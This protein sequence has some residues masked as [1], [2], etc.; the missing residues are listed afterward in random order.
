MK[1]NFFKGGS[2][3]AKISLSSTLFILAFLLGSTSI[4]AQ[5]LQTSGDAL[6]VKQSLLD[7]PDVDG[8]L[9]EVN[10]EYQ[11]VNLSVP[12]DEIAEADKR[13][14]LM[15]LKSLVVEVQKGSGNVVGAFEKSLEAT[16]QFGSRYA[17]EFNTT[18]EIHDF[19]YNLFSN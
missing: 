19:Y 8:F 15:F 1:I 13:I 5:S 9:T 14:R 16:N 7:F 10:A 2:I 11:A 4:N 3:L 6:Q 18:E 17:A 12:A